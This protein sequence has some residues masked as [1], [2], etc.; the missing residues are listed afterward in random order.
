[1]PFGFVPPA[2]EL[3]LRAKWALTRN[4]VQQ[5]LDTHDTANH[6]YDGYFGPTTFAQTIDTFYSSDLVVHTWDIARATSMSDF[7]TISPSEMDQMLAGLATMEAW[8]GGMLETGVGR[9]AN[10]ALC[11][12]PGF[13][14]PPDLSASN[15]YFEVDITEPI[16]MHNGVIEVP[17]GPGIGFAPLPNRLDA[18]GAQWFPLGPGSRTLD[19]PCAAPPVTSGHITSVR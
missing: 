19:Y 15:R 4:A 8:C 9:A 3:D 11:A 13:T 6:G 1:M 16:V 18:L 7:V 2:D 17:T 14:L 12:L 5:A 10:L